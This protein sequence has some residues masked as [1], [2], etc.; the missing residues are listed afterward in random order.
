MCPNI[1]RAYVNASYGLTFTKLNFPALPDNDYIAFVYYQGVPVSIKV[2]EG[3]CTDQCPNECGEKG[4]CN[5]ATGKC[6]CF[7]G[8]QGDACQFCPSC[9]VPKPFYDKPL[10]KKL[11]GIGSALVVL[12]IAVGSFLVIRNKQKENL[13][14]KRKNESSKKEVTTPLLINDSANRFDLRN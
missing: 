6:S 1:I 8:W 4:I 9:P 7:Q 11:V 10:F 5:V 13:Y 3:S 12:I 14:Q 2:C